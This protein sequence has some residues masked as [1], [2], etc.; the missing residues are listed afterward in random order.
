MCLAAFITD[1]ATNAASA[2]A[3][4]AHGT[5]ATAEL[6]SR[7]LTLLGLCCSTLC[8]LPRSAVKALKLEHQA[9][10]LLEV[11]Q[12]GCDQPGLVSSSLGSLAYAVLETSSATGIAIC[13]AWNKAFITNCSAVTGNGC[14][15]A[16][17]A[18]N[19]P[20][21]SVASCICFSCYGL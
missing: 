9:A 14:A 11:L 6:H 2:R 16:C 12:E 10:Q 15:K 7:Q 3:N 8:S 5:A 13:R 18:S 20:H 17:V 1:V 21:T 4:Q 19:L